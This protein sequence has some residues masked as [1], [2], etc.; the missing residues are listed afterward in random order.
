MFMFSFIGTLPIGNIVAGTLSQRFGVRYT[1]AAGGTI[2][3][4]VAILVAI[5]N[6]RLRELY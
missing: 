1:L 5:T 4:V 6:K 2:V 3:T